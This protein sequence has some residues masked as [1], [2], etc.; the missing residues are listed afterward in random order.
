[1]NIEPR[2]ISE[3][4]RQS[5]FTEIPK[6]FTIEGSSMA[7]LMMSGEK[8]FLKPCDSGPLNAGHCYA[9][10]DG[11]SLVLHRHVATYGEVAIFLGDNSR[12][13]QIVPLYDIIGRL[14][15]KKYRHGV[16]RIHLVHRFFFKL[17]R[18]RGALIRRM[19]HTKEKSI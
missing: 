14:C 19:S 3:A 2:L 12:M 6:E 16:G 11:S 10:R 17:F 8:V 7:P 5:L 1:M 15:E 18:I 9:F 4:L 13:P